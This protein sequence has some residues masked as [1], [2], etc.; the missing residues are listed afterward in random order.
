[1][2]YSMDDDTVRRQVFWLLKRLSSY[3]LWKRKKEAWAIFADAYE[4]AVK[5]WPEDDPDA[6]DPNNLVPIYEALRLYE[7]GLD[8]LEKGHRHVWRTQ[9]ELYQLHRPVYQ[10]RSR[11]FGR[12][13][14]RGIQDWPYP[15]KVEQINKLRLAA[16][17]T[18]SNLISETHDQSANIPN[19]D[20][21]LGDARYNKEFYSLPQPVFPKHLPPVPERQD[22]II[23][24]NDTVP[25][26]GIWEPVEVHYHHKWLV[27]PTE[28]KSFTNKGCFNYLISGI[29]APLI[30]VWSNDSFANKGEYVKWR[31]IWED[32]RYCDGIIPDESEYF[33][34]DEPGKRITCQSGER[35]PHSGRWATLAG[36]QQQFVHLNAGVLMP[37]ATQYQ[38]NIY[39]AEIQLPATWS[40][41]QRDDEGSVYLKPEAK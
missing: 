28:V 29:K 21:L 16:E 17:Y 10:V 18:G 4:Y 11:F 33:L 15:P 32:T 40:L 26:D 27:V 23:N 38:S 24:S 9:G 20:F 36:G 13:H 39:A 31:L 37:Q 35:C 8:E 25:C 6:L 3:S 5:T 7:Q 12:C 2:T 19:A 30:S 22:V 14:E 41:L 34:D 1:Q